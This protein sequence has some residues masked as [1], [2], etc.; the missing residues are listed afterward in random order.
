M[1]E[2]LV[3]KQ[4]NLEELK[5][6]SSSTQARKKEIDEKKEAAQQKLSKLRGVM[7]T[8]QVFR[9]RREGCVVM[10]VA[11]WLLVFAIQC[12]PRQPRGSICCTSLGQDQLNASKGKVQRLRTALEAKD[13]EKEELM[14]KDPGRWGPRRA[15]VCPPCT[16]T[17]LSHPPLL[18]LRAL[19]AGC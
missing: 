13:K 11:G 5:S 15:C 10:F 2:E 8:R 1:K 12:P 3:E 4:A 17:H 7:K 6:Q 16:H 18:H 9:T 19:C 14:A